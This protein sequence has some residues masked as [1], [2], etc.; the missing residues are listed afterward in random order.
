MLL[1]KPQQYAVLYEF[2]MAFSHIQDVQH[3]M[4]FMSLASE[5]DR[6]NSWYK[7]G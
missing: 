2:A 1:Y 7:M 3:A 4:K 6:T 5:K